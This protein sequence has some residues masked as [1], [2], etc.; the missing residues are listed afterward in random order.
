MGVVK[1]DV[2]VHVHDMYNRKQKNNIVYC[3]KQTRYGVNGN[4]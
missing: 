1:I 3:I 2:H 4:I